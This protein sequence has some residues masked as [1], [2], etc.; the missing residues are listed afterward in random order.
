MLSV[1][2][3]IWILFYDPVEGDAKFETLLN[4]L[5]A[6]NFIILEQCVAC[7]ENNN[8]INPPGREIRC[9]DI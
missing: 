9:L 5:T 6:I 2:S 4:C 3:N 7:F 8:L 1:I